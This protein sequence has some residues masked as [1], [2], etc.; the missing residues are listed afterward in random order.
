MSWAKYKRLSSSKDLSIFRR[1]T[2]ASDG[3]GGGGPALLLD[4]YP[5]ASAAYSLR[6]L[7]RAYNGS[8]IRVRRSSDNAEQDIGFSG[9]V[10]DTASLLSFC[11]AGSGYVTTW[12]DQS[13]NGK[14]NIQATLLAQPTIVTSGNL[15]TINSLPAINYPSGAF[16]AT[17]LYDVASQSVF[18]VS[19]GNSFNNNFQSLVSWQAQFNGQPPNLA[20]AGPWIRVG[21]ANYYR[22]P[23]IGATDVNDF[24]NS[25]GAMYF[26]GSLHL[27]T[28]SFLNPNI[29]SSFASAAFTR[30]FGMSDITGFNRM[31][32][33][34]VS[35]VIVYPTSQESGYRSAIETDMSNHYS[36]SI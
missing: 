27:V 36:I 29:L 15:K 20:Q 24:T 25:G 13:G 19:E 32:E 30:R 28:D 35:E 21:G 3:G 2:T 31:F 26:N 10:L 12:Y 5:G 22:T 4:L 11:G 18:T 6:R 17:P 34:R 23:S 8:A 14:D 16:T 33:G 1:G 7:N 9:G